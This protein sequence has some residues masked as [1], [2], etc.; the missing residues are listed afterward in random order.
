MS[1]RSPDEIW[2]VAKD[3]GERRL[4]RRWPA[5]V[6]TGFVGGA[7][8]MIG[9]FVLAATSAAVTAA[10]GPELGHLAGSLV[11][12]VGFVML[13]VGR[14]ELFTENFLVPVSTVLARRAQPRSLLRLWVITFV[15]NYAGILLVTLIMKTTGVLQPETLAAAAEPAETL[16]ARDGLPSLLS[17]ILAGAVMTLM[18]WL[19]HA[20]EQDIG[21]IVIALLIGFVIALGTFNHAVVAFGETMLPYLANTTDI[22]LGDIA[23]TLAYA[24]VGNLIGGLGLVTLNR[25]IQAR[26]EPD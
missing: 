16:V 19:T 12:G 3:E 15:A 7:D 22:G 9:V 8:I 18:T 24:I 6:A 13:I 4:A 20:A 14:G 17:A 21:R 10:A 23:R 26:G 1:G 11:F 25:A 2:E 5:L